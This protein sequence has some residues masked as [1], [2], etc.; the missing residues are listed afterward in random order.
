MLKPDILDHSLARRT[1]QLPP[2]LGNFYHESGP[3]GRGLLLS[4]LN[5]IARV[6]TVR[7]ERDDVA[8]NVFGSVLNATTVLVM[9]H[10]GGSAGRTFL[11]LKR[12]DAFSSDLQEI[13]RLSGAFNVTTGDGV[14]G[15][16]RKICAAR[17]E[18]RVCLIYGVEAR[19]ANRHF[20][21]SSHNAAVAAAW[22]RESAR[23]KQGVGADWSQ[24]QLTELAKRG[25]VMGF[26]G[27]EVHNV[28]RMPGLIGHG[29]NIIFVRDSELLKH[30]RRVIS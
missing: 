10:G 8:Q 11:F 30:Q 24:S 2:L 12:E 4:D 9:D 29:S 17:D 15:R 16:G 13:Q 5:G 19:A 6:R 28:H 22:R 3:F 14:R 25:E 23:A 27:V 20:Y 7:E 21:R 18:D 1:M 26:T